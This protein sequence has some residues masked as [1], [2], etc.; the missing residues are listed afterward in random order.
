MTLCQGRE[1]RDGEA[2]A[3]GARK[4]LIR[5]AGMR[6]RYNEC[7]GQAL[8]VKRVATARNRGCKSLTTR[9]FRGTPFPRLISRGSIEA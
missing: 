8:L 2:K 9:E 1:R 4:R 5:E 6:Y 3:A 7:V